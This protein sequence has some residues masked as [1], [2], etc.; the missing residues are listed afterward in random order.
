VE[1]TESVLDPLSPNDLP[2]T[3]RAFAVIGNVQQLG[4]PTAFSAGA[5]TLTFE[6]LVPTGTT[7]VRLDNLIPDLT[8]I[9]A[10]LVD[11]ITIGNSAG[12]PIAPTSGT[13]AGAGFGDVNIRFQQPVTEIGLFVS[14][15]SI[16]VCCCCSRLF[17]TFHLFAY[18]QSGTEIG[19]VSEPVLGATQDVSDLLAFRPVFLGL[20]SSQPIARIVVD[21]DVPPDPDGGTIIF[22]DLTL[23]PAPIG[24]APVGID[25]KPG[26]DPN[27][28][29]LSSNGPGN[30][31]VA[32]AILTVGDLNAADIDVSTVTLGNG[33]GDDTPVATRNNGSLQASFED[34]DDDTDLDLLVRLGR[35]KVHES[36]KFFMPR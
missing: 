28:I 34:V 5:V 32:V 16:T 2:T 10:S 3:T 25:I 27:A 26:S 33:D 22:D 9:D 19:R 12:I 4:S 23:F 20:R 8:F 24:P 6:D 29:N 17:V 18:D 21:N 30:A 31:T 35:S 13:A 7:S 14:P 36:I 15:S 1:W 11:P